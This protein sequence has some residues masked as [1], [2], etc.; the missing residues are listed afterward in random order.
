[1]PP[2]VSACTHRLVRPPPPHTHTYITISYT[3]ILYLLH[4]EKGKE[5]RRKEMRRG[6]SL[7]RIR[8]MPAK[9]SQDSIRK[10]PISVKV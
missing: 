1:M 9:N 8:L 2:L 7:G 6:G 10:L 5:G 4:R 3:F